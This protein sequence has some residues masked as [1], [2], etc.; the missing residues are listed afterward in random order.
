MVRVFG[1]WLKKTREAAKRGLFPLMSIVALVFFCWLTL[2]CLSLLS[3]ARGDVESIMRRNLGPEPAEEDRYDTALMTRSQVKTAIV[4]GLVT[5]VAALFAGLAVLSNAFVVREMRRSRLA[6]E[7]AT[8]AA[9][10]R[11]FRERSEEAARRALMAI[12]SSSSYGGGFRQALDRQRATAL[13]SALSAEEP[14][15]L[16]DEVR[17]RVRACAEATRLLTLP[18]SAFDGFDG[19]QALRVGQ[20]LERTQLT[21]QA[22]LTGDK[23]PEWDDL[24]TGPHVLS[25]IYGPRTA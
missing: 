19:A 11:R 5:M 14:L 12:N 22:Y 4:Q 2:A 9:E 7:A 25:W 20:V 24:P 1:K 3:E 18:E 21:L 6:N 17:S 13:A 10:T 23:A 16:E 8:S 15:I